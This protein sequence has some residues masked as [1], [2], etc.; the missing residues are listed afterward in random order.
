MP[1]AHYLKRFS[2]SNADPGIRD[3]ALRVLTTVDQHA[4]EFT[5]KAASGELFLFEER[6]SIDGILT[7]SEAEWIY[8]N[9][10]AARSSA[11]RPIYDYLKQGA[12]NF[13]CP[14]CGIRH[15]TTLDHYLPQSKHPSF[16]VTYENLVP[17]CMDCNKAKGS[18]SPTSNGDQTI[19]PYFD[20]VQ[21]T[22]WLFARFANQNSVVLEFE[23]KPSNDIDRALAERIS[24]H[25]TKLNL[26][27]LYQA[28]AAEELANIRYRL[29][30]LGDAGGET[31]IRG[32]LKE[33]FDSRYARRKNSWQ[34][35][36]YQACYLSD[37]FIAGGYRLIPEP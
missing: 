4:I 6:Q 16:V 13:I 28:Q 7:R 14:L 17:S 37:W 19:H 21:N 11:G 5:Q 24:R 2:E 31:A 26:N 22:Q 35:S 9:H 10:F 32:H 12:P 29:S 15:V 8:K 30:L 33:T 25:F 20:E 34:S 18:R 1:E 23:A 36:F 3:K 27:E